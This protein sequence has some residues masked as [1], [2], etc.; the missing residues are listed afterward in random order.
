MTIELY[1]AGMSVCSEKVRILLAERNTPFVSHLLDEYPTEIH[2]FVSHNIPLEL[3][4]GTLNSDTMWKLQ[5]G[6]LTGVEPIPQ[7]MRQP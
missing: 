7:Q 3:M 1:H 4:V 2:F 6:E 5:D